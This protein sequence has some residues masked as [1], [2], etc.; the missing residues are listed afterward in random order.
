VFV[1]DAPTRQFV[2]KRATPLALL[3]ACLVISFATGCALGASE[4]GSRF[5]SC[6]SISD[7]GSESRPATVPT[8]AARLQK[9][10]ISIAAAA[11]A[12]QEDWLLSPEAPAAPDRLDSIRNGRHTHLRV[13]VLRI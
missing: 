3:A 13:G 7:D 6:P 11:S 2:R 8:A 5:C 1:V 4:S 10:V 12:S 9:R